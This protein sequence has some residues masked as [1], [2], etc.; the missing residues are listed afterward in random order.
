MEFRSLVKAIESLLLR[1]NLSDKYESAI[2]TI[3]TL[4]GMATGKIAFLHM[5]GHRYRIYV[6][7]SP[8]DRLTRKA[9]VYC[10]QE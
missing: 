7:P 6:T 2:R 5:A 1:E 9:V 8:E 10:Q 4:R 3:S